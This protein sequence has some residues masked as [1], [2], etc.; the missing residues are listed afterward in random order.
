MKKH[1]FLL[2]ILIALLPLTI[3]SAGGFSSD[4]DAVEKAAKSVLML[5]V[6]HDGEVIATGSGFVAF[7]NKT[8]VTNYHVIED[9][10]MIFAQSDDGYEYIIMQVCIADEAKDLAILRFYSPTDLRPLPLH[11]AVDQ[12]RIE[13]VVAIGSPRGLKNTVSTGNVSAVFEEDGTQ[14]LQFTAPISNGSSGGALFNND[15]E[16][17]G[18]TSMTRKDSQNINFAV[19]AKEIQDLY[20]KWDGSTYLFSSSPST[21]TPTIPPTVKPTST[22]TV[23]ITLKPTPMP[24]VSFGISSFKIDSLSS[25]S[26]TLT[27]N[28]PYSPDPI[29][30]EIFYKERRLAQWTF[31]GETTAG[32]ITINN[33]THSTSYD[34]KIIATD[35]KG[36]KSAPYTITDKTPSAKHK[37]IATIPPYIAT[38]YK[39]G[40]D[41]LGI[42]LIKKE[43]QSYGYYTANAELSCIYNNTMVERIK[44]FQKN[45]K[46]KVTGQIDRDFL[47]KLYSGNAVPTNQFK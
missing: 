9:A 26:A 17:I 8:L 44:L 3:A 14:W 18:V 42:L 46:L 35:S 27:W 36:N 11:T 15:G 29:T 34:F 2:I 1:F 38:S 6:M 22:P 19:H 23:Q 16:V 28:S 33:L 10:D 41:E 39:Y 13:S 4:P 47:A 5:E 25:S 7:D 20:E 43:M 45:N 24:T 30:Y 40:D 31:I 21:A 32:K 37:T 12:K